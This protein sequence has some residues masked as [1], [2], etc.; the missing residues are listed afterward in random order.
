METASATLTKMTK[1]NVK[2]REH[3]KQLIYFLWKISI[4]KF[5]FNKHFYLI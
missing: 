1:F 3:D 2:K 4:A 5:C